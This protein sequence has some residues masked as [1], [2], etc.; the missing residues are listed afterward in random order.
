[1]NGNAKLMFNKI[2]IH[3]LSLQYFN[4]SQ[5]IR[6]IRS[7][8]KVNTAP[9]MPHAT[10]MHNLTIIFDAGPLWKQTISNVLYTT[11]ILYTYEEWT[12]CPSR[13]TEALWLKLWYACS[14]PVSSVFSSTIKKIIETSR[15]IKPVTMHVDRSPIDSSLRKYWTVSDVKSLLQK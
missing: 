7:P 1:M 2:C 8:G 15:Y 3:R 11:W 12:P 13:K 10:A 9:T 6:A 14:T 4:E 5:C